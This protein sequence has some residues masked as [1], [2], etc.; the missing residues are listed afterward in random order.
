MTF[1]EKVNKRKNEI[2][3]IEKLKEKY[4]KTINEIKN[5]DLFKILPS[6]VKNKFQTLEQTKEIYVEEEL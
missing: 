5:N 2:E 1:Q 4:E 6:W 3:N